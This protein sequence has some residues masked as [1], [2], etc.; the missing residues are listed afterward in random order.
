MLPPPTPFFN[1]LIASLLIYL[2]LLS[3]YSLE[4]LRGYGESR[5]HGS[6]ARWT[7][8][9]SQWLSTEISEI[10]DFACLITKCLVL[11]FDHPDFIWKVQLL[12]IPCATTVTPRGSCRCFK[13]LVGVIILRFAI[14][15]SSVPNSFLLPAFLE[16]ATRR[17]LR[18]RSTEWSGPV[19]AIGSPLHRYTW[20]A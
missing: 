11:S 14:V 2:V 6:S 3:L 8:V 12:Q 20:R 10:N 16:P 18:R 4:L 5:G 17:V 13:S 1:N 7:N 19:L 15:S 9:P